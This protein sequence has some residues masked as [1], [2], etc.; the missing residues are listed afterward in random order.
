ML[1]SHDAVILSWWSGN[2]GNMVMLYEFSCSE[3]RGQLL[4]G[5]GNG[6]HSNEERVGSSD[7]AKVDPSLC[8]IG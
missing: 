1:C 6:L 2:R 3:P 7:Q 4:I 5:V 8:A